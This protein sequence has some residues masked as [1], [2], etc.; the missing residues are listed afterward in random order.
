MFDCPIHLSNPQD[1]VET[2]ISQLFTPLSLIEGEVDEGEDSEGEDR[3]DS[4]VNF[5]LGDSEQT[6][7]ERIFRIVFSREYAF[8]L[9]LLLNIL[10]LISYEENE[11]DLAKYNEVLQ[12]LIKDLDSIYDLYKKHYPFQDW[13]FVYQEG[14]DIVPLRDVEGSMTRQVISTLIS[15]RA[16]LGSSLFKSIIASCLGPTL[17]V[18]W[19]QLELDLNAIFCSEYL[20]SSGGGFNIL[21][22]SPTPYNEEEP[23][24]KAYYVVNTLN[25]QNG[26]LTLPEGLVASKIILISLN[27]QILVE[28]FD[29]SP[30]DE[31]SLQFYDEL[32]GD[33]ILYFVQLNFVSNNISDGKVYADS[34]DPIRGFI[35]DKV[36]NVT[37]GVDTTL[38]KAFVKNYGKVY[39]DT[40]DTVVGFL[41]DKIDNITLGVNTTTHKIYVKSVD[42]DIIINKP[43]L[44]TVPPH[45][46]SYRDLTCVLGKNYY[47]GTNEDGVY[48]AYPLPTTG[49]VSDGKVKIDANDIADYLGNKIDAD[50][51]IVYN[52]KL[53]VSK[54]DSFLNIKDT[55]NSYT[56]KSNRSVLVS[57]GENSLTFGY[58]IYILPEVPSSDVGEDGDICFVI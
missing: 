14:A 39:A 1:V 9:K 34:L 28:E 27:N 16:V 10:H 44:S 26:I 51:I 7:Y 56:G 48:G 37:L 32:P 12:P 53:K 20:S 42:W 23:L 57:E 31:G 40:Q 4:I 8:R 38:H 47:L 29:Y 52:N 3:E 41:T 24:Y 55:P 25:I 58:R 54:L 6:L 15:L 18:I 11:E 30:I 22:T 21:E 50:T 46:H 33:G 17:S 5:L 13:E 45:V 36:D 43:D 2:I 49:G 19:N 35:I